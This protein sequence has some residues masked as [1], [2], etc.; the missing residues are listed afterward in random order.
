MDDYLIMLAE[1]YHLDCDRYD[2]TVC[3]GMSEDG[4]PM[5]IG[6][7]ELGLVNQNARRVIRRLQHLTFDHEGLMKAI[8]IV[9]A[10]Q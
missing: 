1:Q 8:S 5:P 6:P 2:A 7:Y 3:S 4:T 10:R 9:G